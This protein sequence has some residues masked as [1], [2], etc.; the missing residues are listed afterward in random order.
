MSE[1]RK[2]AQITSAKDFVQICE[3]HGQNSVL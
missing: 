1:I 3:K 2:V